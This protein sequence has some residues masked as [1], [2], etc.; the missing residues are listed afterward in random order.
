MIV[1]ALVLFAA[2]SIADSLAIPKDNASENIL[3]DAY[4]LEPSS[5]TNKTFTVD[6][7]PSILTVVLNATDKIQMDIETNN[8]K[9]YSKNESQLNHNFRLGNPGQWV[10]TFRNNHAYRVNYTYSLTLITLT[11]TIEHPQSWLFFPTFIAGEIAICSIIPI[12]FFD[13]IKRIK[14]K[15]AE[16]LLFSIIIFS[17]FGLMPLIS[18]VMGT[19]TPFVTPNSS[20]MEPTIWPGDLAIVTGTNPKT[21]SVGDIVVY[22]KIV[23]DLNNPVAETVNYQTMHRIV[24]FV[25]QNNQRFFVTQ[26]D[27][28][29]NEDG[30]F[31]PEEGVRGKVALTVPYVGSAVM[32]ISRIEI[33]IGITV[34][35]MIILALW[36]NKKNKI[37]IKRNPSP[38]C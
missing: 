15:S 20:S 23:E 21:L 4:F 29:P 33:K 35:T 28:N 25:E 31:V 26:G 3:Q 38:I 5:E 11:T 34:M 22:D 6:N 24:R 14:R 2:G 8:E 12:T 17:A 13:N 37:E 30:W 27:N 36:P 32:F 18:I 9:E 19:S 1:I 16:I 10:V 7:P